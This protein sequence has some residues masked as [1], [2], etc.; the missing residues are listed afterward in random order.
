MAC[1]SRTLD[2]IVNSD[3]LQEA[4]FNELKQER[5]ASPKRRT[6]RFE[7]KSGKKMRIPMKTSIRAST[8]SRCFVPTNS[9]RPTF[10]DVPTQNSTLSKIEYK[11]R[12]LEPQRS[13]EAATRICEFTNLGV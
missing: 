8:L 9:V 3:G 7:F 2:A 6:S 13:H 4:S 11:E 10:E 12:R 1:D 5:F